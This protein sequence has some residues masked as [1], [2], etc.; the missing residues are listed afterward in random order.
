MRAK[1]EDT[2]L[3]YRLLLQAFGVCVWVHWWYEPS[4][5]RRAWWPVS[6]GAVRIGW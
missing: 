3:S 4:M 2:R 6:F 5:R 1:I